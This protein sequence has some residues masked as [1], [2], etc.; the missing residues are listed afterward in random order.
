MSRAWTPP[1]AVVVVALD[2][3]GQQV[4]R[5]QVEIIPGAPVFVRLPL[6]TTE[7]ALQGASTPTYR[8][9]VDLGTRRVITRRRW[10]WNA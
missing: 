1:L 9:R 8:T 7:V 10:W 5:I 4:R 3:D 2:G 6:G